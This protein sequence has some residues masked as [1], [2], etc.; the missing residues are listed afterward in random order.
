MQNDYIIE[1]SKDGYEIL[2][3]KKGN[4]WIYIG[5]KYN[6]KNEI[7]KFI[8][9]FDEDKDK[10]S[11]FFVY[12]FASGVYIKELRKKFKKNKIIVYEPNQNLK[13][14]INNKK[15]VI[16]DRNLIILFCERDEIENYL[17]YYIQDYD[18]DN[19]KFAYLHNYLIYMDDLKQTLQSIKNFMTTLRINRNTTM[20][21]SK[22]WFETII[23]N[24]PELV[25]GTPINVYKNKYKDKPA[26]IVSAGPSLEKNIDELKKIH[27]GM[28]IISGGRTLKPLIEKKINPHLLVVA[29]PGEISY[30]LVEGYIE[31]INIP[32]LFYEGTNEKVVCKHKGDKIFYSTNKFIDDICEKEIM[33]LSCGGSVSHSMVS[34]ALV[35]GCNPIIFVGQD[36]A[37]NGEKRYSS[38]TRNRDGSDPLN[39]NENDNYIMVEGINRKQV[40]TNGEFDYFRRS[41]EKIIKENPNTTF[42]NSTEGGARIHG[43]KEMK[44]KDAILKYSSSDIKKI[45]KIEYD[46]D[47]KCNAIKLLKKAKKSAKNIINYSEE[48]VSELKKM[49]THILLKNTCEINEHLTI[50]DKI[51][52]KIKKE[53]KN[54]ELVKSLIYPIIYEILNQRNKVINVENEEDKI[55]KIIKENKKLYTAFIEQLQFALK[56]INEILVILEK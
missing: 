31:N 36:L 30:Q 21:F 32:L 54:V 45:E 46:V 38:I 16:E 10:N 49:E 27:N 42:I 28:I 39:R 8:N 35:F 9:E 52:K 48:A 51:D 22:R 47:L 34:A 44:L 25:N 55:K 33:P 37:F 6:M 20:F 11:I 40:R 53:Y 14:Y 50:L 41:F 15:W 2:K 24:I 5:S 56:Y 18:L 43:T 1:K 23:R 4:K 12:G 29:D 7:D 17:S 19:T 3:I 13:E 26:V